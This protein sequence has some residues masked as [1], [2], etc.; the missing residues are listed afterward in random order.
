VNSA[1]LFAA[2]E[3]GDVAG[4][5]SALE[6]DPALASTRSA[7][8]TSAV[9]AAVYRGDVAMVDAVLT[10]RPPVDQFDAA[11]LG[12]TTRLRALLDDDPHAV[13]DRSNDGFTALHLASFF[14]H[15]DAARLL[16]ERGADPSARADNEMAVEPLHS[17]AA[18]RAARIVELLLEQGADPNAR[19]RGGFVP[20]HAAAANGDVD[21]VRVLLRH[22][23]G[24]T[25]ATDEGTT[26]ADFAA[27]AGHVDVVKVLSGVGG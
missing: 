4:V 23:A 6:V 7:D 19:Q 22:G 14:D 20:L 26:A 16:L 27:E 9:R 17:A 21:S 10:G 5:R 12:D 8:G 18:G 2:I 11:A 25:V 1:E 13:N 24:R 15:V 3:A